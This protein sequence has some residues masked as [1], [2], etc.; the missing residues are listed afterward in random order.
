MKK[1]FAILLTLAMLVSS[2]SLVACGKKTEE[3]AK[4]TYTVTWKNWDGSGIKF[5]ENVPEGT[6]PSFGQADPTRPDENGV[7][8]AFDHWDP[9]PAPITG[10]VTYTAVYREVKTTVTATEF[11]VAM[12]MDGKNFTCTQTFF[13]QESRYR[14]LE[15][16]SFFYEGF[17]EGDNAAVMALLRED[18][19][20]DVGRTFWFTPD[21]KPAFPPVEEATKAEAAL[22]LGQVDLFRLYLSF[23]SYPALAYDETTHTYSGTTKVDDDE[24]FHVTL[25]FADGELTYVKM[26]AT[27]VT[28]EATYSARGTTEI[29]AEER[30]WFYTP[31]LAMDLNDDNDY[32]DCMEARLGSKA[33]ESKT[34]DTYLTVAVPDDFDPALNVLRLSVGAVNEFISKETSNY[35]DVPY[36]NEDVRVEILWNGTD[37]A[38]YDA[39]E[40]CYTAVLTKTEN[41]KEVCVGPGEYRLQVRYTVLKDLKT[42]GENL[43]MAGATLDGPRTVTLV[44][45][46]ENGYDSDQ[47]IG[48]DSSKAGDGAMLLVKLEIP[49][50]PS[51]FN[52]SEDSIQLLVQFHNETNDEYYTD[53]DVT[54]EIQFEGKD[55]CEYILSNYTFLA[56]FK[57]T[58]GGKEV[59]LGA[60][61]YEVLLRYTLKKD[62]K[63][64]A[65][66]NIELVFTI[67]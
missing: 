38:V 57:K 20:F 64:G 40:E 60:G 47:T 11:A 3:T 54:V 58:E 36:T 66:N 15:D 17:I 48:L 43:L 41:G 9:T 33:G 51:S 30:A 10:N 61:T 62:F 14:V 49:K 4:A 25:R 7:Q 2:V 22:W 5:D 65:K 18:G 27:D 8:Y 50:L 34:V 59:S 29:T 52:P 53:D 31:A 6:V 21:G 55:I 12:V 19:M 13:G 63:A 39:G 23:V 44:A 16:G 42:T 24:S 67:A 46:E 45:N 1:L 32:D 37:I 26:T 35:V 56:E 28:A